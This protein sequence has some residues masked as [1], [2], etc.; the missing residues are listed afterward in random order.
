MAAVMRSKGS[1]SDLGVGLLL[2]ENKGIARV[3]GLQKYPSGKLDQIKTQQ[4]DLG[5]REM[6]Q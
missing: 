6:P 2:R 4:K 1:L 3:S 5:A